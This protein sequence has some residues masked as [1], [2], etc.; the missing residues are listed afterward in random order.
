MLGPGVLLYIASLE[1]AILIFHHVTSDVMGPVILS[2]T[3]IA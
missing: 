2:F 1:Y 3:S